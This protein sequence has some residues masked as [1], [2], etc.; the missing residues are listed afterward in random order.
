MR[1]KRRLVLALMLVVFIV[2]DVLFAYGIATFSTAKVSAQ[3]VDEPFSLYNISENVYGTQLWTTSAGAYL[4]SVGGLAQ[5]QVNGTAKQAALGYESGAAVVLTND[6]N[7]QYFPPNSRSAAFEIHVNGTPVLLGLTERYSSNDYRPWDI[8]LLDTNTSGSFIVTYFVSSPLG[9]P[10]IRSLSTAPLSFGITPSMDYV[11]LGYENGTIATFRTYDKVFTTFVNCDGPVRSLAMNGDE[12][13]YA[14]IAGNGSLA[15]YGFDL[16]S[17]VPYLTRSVPSDSQ[18]LIIRNDKSAFYTAGDEVFK[19]ARDG[20]E[21]TLKVS[22]MTSFSVALV[23][24]RIAV[25]TPGKT[26]GYVLGQDVPVWECSTGLNGASVL[27]SIDGNSVLAWSGTKIAAMDDLR[28]QLGDGTLW[29]VLGVL[30][31]VEPLSLAV[32]AFE[33]RIR[34]LGIG[35]LFAI[36]VG[37]IAGVVIATAVQ[38]AAAIGWFGGQLSYA[39]ISAAIGAV[40]CLFS[41]VSGKAVTSVI[42]GTAA[43][44]VSS[45]PIA[46]IAAFALWATGYSF[47][48]SDPVLGSGLNVVS[49]GFY[50]GVAGAIAGYALAYLLKEKKKR[51]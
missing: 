35:I 34:A 24:D 41:W 27:S 17:I 7:V 51:Q 2:A 49:A 10:L 39:F 5:L 31:L 15:L 46:L 6:S 25:T 42:I 8:V 28:V 43:G 9:P 50:G 16:D 4:G 32:V 36:A 47:P 38:D 20:G 37:A 11:L 22:G 21:S 13:A 44:F 19:E 45:I 30:V 12:S 48:G 33:K 3:I 40:A 1:K 29:V 18:G 23:S 14:A 26:L